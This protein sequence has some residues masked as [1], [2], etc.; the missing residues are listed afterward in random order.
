MAVDRAQQ[1]TPLAEPADGHVFDAAEL[2]RLVAAARAAQDVIVGV[3]PPPDVALRATDLLNETIGLL[4]PYRLDP[5]A[6][7]SWGDIHRMTDTRLLAPVLHRDQLDV[8]TVVGRITFGQMY[9]G[10]N[11]AVHGG[12]IPLVFDEA[13][14]LVANLASQTR[15]A[16]LKVDYRSVT[17]VG[18]ELVLRGWVERREG[19][20]LF[21]AGTLHHGEQLTAEAHALFVVLQPDAP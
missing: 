2:R 12:A 16:S 11:G 4:A 17:P 14:A 15:T 6:P 21:L 1:P 10:A 7:S 3:L 19:R 9:A 5:A 20:K 18:R 13:L 8:S